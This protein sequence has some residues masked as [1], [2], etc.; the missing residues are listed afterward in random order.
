MLYDHILM[1]GTTGMLS[2]ATFDLALKTNQLTCIARTRASLLQLKGGLDPHGP[3][4]EWIACDYAN[5]DQFMAEIERVWRRRPFDLV[6][7]WMHRSGDESLNRLQQFLVDQN[8]ELAFYHVLGSA[9]ADPS[10]QNDQ[11]KSRGWGA[12][13]YYEVVLGFKIENGRSRWLHHGEISRGL[14]DA[15]SSS[16]E[17]FIVGTVEPWEERP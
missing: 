14:L 4:Y 9:A 16:Q 3:T 2:S 13:S 1:I 7:V 11:F 5:S 10:K 8:R 15:I 17:R 6:V 12:V